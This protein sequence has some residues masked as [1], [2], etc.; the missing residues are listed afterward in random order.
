MLE[1]TRKSGKAGS[2]RPEARNS[3][4]SCFPHFPIQLLFSAPHCPRGLSQVIDRK[5][6]LE[7]ICRPLLINLLI[8]WR[9]E[10]VERQLCLLTC[11][12][13]L[14]GSTPFATYLGLAQ[15]SPEHLPCS[16]RGTPL[17]MGQARSKLESNP[18]LGN[19]CLWA[20]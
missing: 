9:E 13:Q 6:N 2:L 12:E 1:A 14:Q 18:N 10:R 3:A 16:S 11:P 15:M 17:S 5:G 19:V 8:G 7:S 20:A 4:C